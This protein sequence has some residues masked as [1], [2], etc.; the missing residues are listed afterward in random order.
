MITWQPACWD[1]DSKTSP[2][3]VKEIA[4]GAYDSY[5]D[6]FG[7]MLGQFLNG[8]DGV[9]GTEDDRRVYLRLGHEMNTG[10]YPWAPGHNSAITP[11]DYINMW[12]RVRS[13][14]N[15]L[16][17]LPSQ[18]QYIWCPNNFDSG[19]TIPLEQLYPGSDVVDWLGFDIYNGAE[20]FH[21]P[22]AAASNLGD[23]IVGRLN[24]LGGGGKPIMACEVGVTLSTPG[25]QGKLEW[26]QE[27]FWR[28]VFQWR[29]SAVVYFNVDNWAVRGWNQ[30]DLNGWPQLVGDPNNGLVGPNVPGSGA[31]IITD[32]LFWG[33]GAGNGVQVWFGQQP[34]GGSGDGGQNPGGSS[35][36][37]QNGGSGGGGGAGDQNSNGGQPIPSPPSLPNDN[38]STELTMSNSTDVNSTT[39]TGSG[40][41]VSTGVATLSPTGSGVNAN[42]ASTSTLTSTNAKSAAVGVK[43][44]ILFGLFLISGAF[45]TISSFVW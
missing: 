1:P 30:P 25:L 36:D 9:A 14:F 42:G 10:F 44:S 37:G 20:V 33:V 40:S 23:S 6:F 38:N 8:G 41:L 19:S 32:E 11:S 21:V 16:G 15:A 22:W 26:L 3:F 5:I 43:G 2:T 31:R 17:L 4:E 7:R 35:G 28:A 45:L 18:I 34:Q 24:A 13:R 29:L 39:T 27:F 12:R